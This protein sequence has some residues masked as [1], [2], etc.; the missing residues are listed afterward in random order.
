[1]V[2]HVLAARVALDGITALHRAAQHIDMIDFQL[3]PDSSIN[4]N[5][6]QDG[7]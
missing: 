6:R 7:H 2:R 4:V 3:S 5:I 1:M